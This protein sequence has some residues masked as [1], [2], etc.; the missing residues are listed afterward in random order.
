VPIHVSYT[1]DQ[2]DQAQKALTG[3][4]T[5]GKLAITLP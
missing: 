4:H 5:Q 1:L 2:A 3:Q